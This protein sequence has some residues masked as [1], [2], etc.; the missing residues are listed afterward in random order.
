MLDSGYDPRFYTWLYEDFHGPQTLGPS[1]TYSSLWDIVD[2]SSSGTPT[3]TVGGTNGEATI[4][5]DSAN[6]IQNVCLYQSD[7]LN[8]DIDL[9]QYAKFGVKCSATFNAANTLSFGLASARADDVDTIAAHA[10]FRVIGN[11]NVVVES[12]DGTTDRDDIATG[13][14]LAATYKHFVIDFTGGKSNVK[15]YCNG[16]RLAPATTFNMSAYSSGFQPYL[17]LQKTANTNTQNAAIDYVYLLS[18]RA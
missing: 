1:P 10:S 18:K 8:W 2:T 17:Q 5:F 12:D 14:T 11:N 9:I 16:Q 3:Y 13:V 15:F 6:E 4:T 7:I